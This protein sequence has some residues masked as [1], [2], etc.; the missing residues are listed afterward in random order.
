ML[1]SG[2]TDITLPMPAGWR[3][4][5]DATGFP[6][7]YLP[8]AEG[9]TADAQWNMEFR[10]N[11]IGTKSADV[12]AHIRDMLPQVKVDDTG[13][14][15]TADGHEAG[16][17]RYHQEGNAAQGENRMYFIIL[18]DKEIMWISEHAKLELWDKHAA[19]L[20]GITDGVKL[21]PVP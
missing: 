19:A 5:K 7:V 15:K 1:Q 6:V 9:N 18:S 4:R 2:K 12:V 17:V 3:S 13:T 20:A 8:P 16:F 11:D 14:T 10:Q 21:K